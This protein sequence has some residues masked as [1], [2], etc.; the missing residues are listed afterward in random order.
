MGM[1]VIVNSPKRRIDR[2]TQT[3]AQGDY[4]VS[5]FPPGIHNLFINAPGFWKHEVAGIT[6]R[7]GQKTRADASLQVNT[8]DQWP[9][10]G[11]SRRQGL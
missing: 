4:L 10:C 8:A 1:Q 6:M 2:V 5:D 11:H 9:G 3:N 7:V